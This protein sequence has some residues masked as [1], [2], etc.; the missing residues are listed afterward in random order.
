MV[1]TR[2]GSPSCTPRATRTIPLSAR[3]VRAT[4]EPPG[5]GVASGA[6]DRPAAGGRL[7]RMGGGSRDH[8][9]SAPLLGV[10]RR[11]GGVLS[12]ARLP[13]GQARDGPADLTV[14]EPAATAG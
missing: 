13:D 5:P 6:G 2:W 12:R 3:P 8:R 4:P 11:P 7:A 9:G 10:R 1:K 14:I